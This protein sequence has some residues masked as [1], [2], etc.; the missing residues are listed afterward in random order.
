MST[1]F[2]TLLASACAAMLL[3]ACGGNDAPSAAFTSVKI[4]GD[5]LS[6]TGA[7]GF[8]NTVQSS[9]G[10]PY[11]LWVDLIANDTTQVPLCNFYQ[12]TALTQF[13]TLPGC[14]NHA[15]AGG[16]IQHPAQGTA[17]SIP[18]QL[19]DLRAQVGQAGFDARALVLIN[20]GG[21]DGG[22][23]IAAYL[24]LA[25]SALV[26][27]GAAG[28]YAYAQFLAP[29]LGDAVLAPQQLQAL[30]QPGG[31]EAAAISYMQALA[32]RLT[33][34]IQTQV[35]NAGAQHVVVVTVPDLSRTPR[36]RTILQALVA[37]QVAAGA[38]ALQ[39]QQQAASLQT[40]FQ[41]WVLAFNHELK[42]NFANHPQVAV[43]DIFEQLGQ[44]EANPAQYGLDNA[45]TAV[46][47]P[48]QAPSAQNPLP[49]YDVRQC[50]DTALDALAPAQQLAAGWWNRYAFA[51]DF[52][53]T[54]RGHELMADAVRSAL[55][56][57]GWH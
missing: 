10:T 51:D 5:S 55:Q 2:K 14:G 47:P 18:Q 20:G 48:V 15:V 21:N 54:P 31:A 16:R 37:S 35:L 11:P 4:V 6:D 33:A 1:S 7:Y 56:A 23:L 57:K 28:V 52:H 45:T 8:R 36:L 27:Q 38:S 13:N 17:L 9:T 39:A 40:L 46:C 42:A 43:A 49:I 32:Q 29:V 25:Q 19:A 24:Q 30:A 53:P 12:A 44:W 41:N 3:A 34:D 50:T 22:D 26:G